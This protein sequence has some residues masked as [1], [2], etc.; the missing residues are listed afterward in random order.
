MQKLSHPRDRRKRRWLGALIIGVL[1]TVVSCGFVFVITPFHFIGICPQ[2]RCIQVALNLAAQ[3]RS[4]GVVG[5]D[6]TRAPDDTA[7][8]KLPLGL[9]ELNQLLAERL[10]CKFARDFEAADSIKEKLEELGISVHDGD[11]LWRADSKRFRQRRFKCATADAELVGVDLDRVD[12]LISAHIEANSK[13]DYSRADDLRADLLEMGIQ[14]DDR[15]KVWRWLGP[16][17]HNYRCVNVQDIDDDLDLQLVDETIR[18]RGVAIVRKNRHRIDQ[19]TEKLR[20]M[21]VLL[22]DRHRQWWFV[23]RKR[24][25]LRLN[26][27]NLV[28]V[29]WGG[30]RAPGFGCLRAQDPP[31]SK[32]PA[33]L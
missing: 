33:G 21:G 5:H 32:L 26:F 15:V 12:E 18:S 17:G 8:E 16:I 4:F 27:E 6:Y 11:K 31:S 1:V 23:R 9:S 14:I 13:R 3:A 7:G 19:L 10:K 29:R 22:D 28:P 25:T 30:R 24:R 20:H 2:M